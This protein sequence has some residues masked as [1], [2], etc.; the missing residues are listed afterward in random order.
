MAL[1]QMRHLDQLERGFAAAAMESDNVASP[2]IVGKDEIVA[3]VA[4]SYKVDD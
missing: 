2:F 4:V 1:G 3:R